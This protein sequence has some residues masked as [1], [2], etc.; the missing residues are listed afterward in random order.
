[1]SVIDDN[2]LERTVKCSVVTHAPAIR[3]YSKPMQNL[4]P[5]SYCNTTIGSILKGQN[6]K[7]YA[8]ILKLH[9]KK[10]TENSRKDSAK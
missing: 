1:M 7:L 9:G 10:T 2:F 3:Y 8:L 5:I 4:L 6:R